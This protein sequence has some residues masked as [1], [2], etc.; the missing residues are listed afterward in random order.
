M[1]LIYNAFTISLGERTQQFG[2]L[3]SVGATEKQLRHAVVFEG[4]V[5]SLIGIPLGTFVGIPSVQL[6]TSLSPK[7]LAT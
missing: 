4:L 2:I 6:V 1:L 3:M 5:I 7:I